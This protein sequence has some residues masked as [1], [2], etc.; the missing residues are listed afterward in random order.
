[1]Q[2]FNTPFPLIICSALG[3]LL[4]ACLLSGTDEAIFLQLNKLS[5][6]LPDY[7]WGFLTTLSDPIVAPLLVFSLFYR[8]PLFLRAFFIAIMLALVCNYSLKYGFG[9]ERPTALLKPENYSAIGPVITSPSFPSGHTLTI[10]TLMALV[11]CWY[12][13]RTISIFVFS[14]AAI[15]SFSR[16]SVGAHWPSDVLFGA[17]VG[18]FTGWLAVEINSRLDKAISVN[19]LLSGYF[20]ALFAGILSLVNKTPY[21]SGQWLSTAV[22][23]FTIAYALKSITELLHRQKG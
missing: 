4:A 14:L 1:M 15:I 5:Q 10:F 22:A 11:S 13:K 3:L 16:I 9:I 17:V 19:I 20:I 21:T 7:L 12:L 2:R 6:T 23:L 18:C 8:N